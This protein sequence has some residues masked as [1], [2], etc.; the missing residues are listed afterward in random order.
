MCGIVGSLVFNNSDF[1][2]TSSYINKMRDIDTMILRGPDGAG[3]W[4]SED[5]KVGLGHRRLSIIDLSSNANQPMSNEDGTIWV[6]FN[7]EIYNYKD[8][9]IELESLNKYVWKTNHSDTEV[10]VHAFEEW[11]IECLQKFRGM[12]GIAIWDEKNQELWVI[13]DRLGIKPVYYSIHSGRINFSSDIN[14]LLEDEQQPREVDEEALYNYLSFLTVPAPKTL[15]KGISKLQCGTFIKVKKNGDIET[16]KYWDMLDVKNNIHLKTEKE[17]S[18]DILKELKIS[19]DLRKVSDV[20]VGV[21]LSGGI[22]SSVNAALFSDQGA[23]PI[24]T[25]TIA[26]SGELSKHKNE[27][28]EASFMAESI[29]ALHTIRTVSQNEILHNTNKFIRL[30]GEPLSDPVCGAQYYVSEAAREKGIIVCQIGEGSDELFHGYTSWIKLHKVEALSRIRLPK[31]IKKCAL[32][33]GK[34]IFGKSS[35]HYELL[36]RYS[37][38]QSTF[39]GT[40][41][42]FTEENK[43]ALFNQRMN[44]KFKKYSSWSMI[45]PFYQYFIENAKEK[46]VLNWMTYIDLN[47]RMADLLLPKVDKM[48]MGVSLEA[49]VPFLDYKF[50]EMAMNIP[51]KI[52][53]G[54]VNKNKYLLKK[55]VRG[56]IP[57][58]VIDRKKIGFSLPVDDWYK[59]SFKDSISSEILQFCKDTDY[60]KL[61]EVE[62]ILNGN[63]TI[64]VWSLYTLALW[65]KMYIKK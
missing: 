9:R 2:L 24:N 37:K 18:D 7:G 52:K 53:M 32:K 5:R 47:I 49:R 15:F 64:K 59:G 21:F 10:I 45:Q 62:K 11:G 27:D 1:D 42:I 51:E 57:D 8:I 19:V 23:L 22:D 3:T 46:S 50:V 43:R 55:S 17:I 65:W 39:W 54:N 35:F 4:I 31:I 20:P 25:F 30:L 48:G 28:K 61:D 56:I 40:N 58:E 13:R 44:E 14:A 41:D 29:N 26:F 36:K 34:I 16:N 6:S 12:F 60:F 38:N 63:S 33:A